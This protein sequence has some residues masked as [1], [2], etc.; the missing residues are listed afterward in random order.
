MRHAPKRQFAIFLTIMIFFAAFVG[1]NSCSK[2]DDTG[3]G[4]GGD[5]SRDLVLDGIIL[6]PKS[7]ATSDTLLATAIVTSDTTLPGDFARYKWTSDGGSFLEDDLSTV[8]W[9]APDTSMMFTLNVSASNEVSSAATSSNVFVS[10]VH[11]LVSAGAGEMTMDPSG[12]S[13]HYFS[14]TVPPANLFFNGLG[15]SEVNLSTGNVTLRMSPRRSFSP[16]LSNDL[17]MVA[18]MVPGFSGLVQV[19]YYDLGASAE[20]IIPNTIFFQRGPQ[21]MWPDFSPDK[22]LLAYQVWFPDL[23]LPPSQGGVDTFVVAIWD[24]A[25]ETEKRVAVG[26]AASGAA[27]LN[28]QPTFSTDGNHLVYLADTT[29]TGEWELYALPVVGGTVPVDTLTPPVRLTNTNGNMASGSVPLNNP[30]IWNPVTPLLATLDDDGLIRLV[31]TD[32]SGDILV[33]IPG[34]VSS[35]VWSPSGN[36]LAV[37]AGNLIYRVSTSGVPTLIWEGTAGDGF[38]DLAWASDES[39]LLYSVRRLGDSWYEILDLTGNLGFT[40]PLRVSA[41]IPQG[42]AADYRSIGSLS[43]VWAASAPTAYMLFFDAGPTPRICWMDFSGLI[44]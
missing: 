10:R 42:N 16:T 4:P 36:E 39:L 5:G 11:P 15:V 40:I 43:P 24:I 7:P 31:P 29:G 33:N 17:S 30:K 1:L 27:G 35:L 21:Y 19:G 8:R 3:T 28:F 20:T 13:L 18:Y 37:S 25:T 22:S 44:P 32:G 14:S 38:N 6:N 26:G 23:I 12:T 41:G 9:V 34:S 2:E